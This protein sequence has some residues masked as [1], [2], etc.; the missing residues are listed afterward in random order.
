MEIFESHAKYGL[1]IVSG[2]GIAGEGEGATVGVGGIK[3]GFKT[4]QIGVK[5]VPVYTIPPK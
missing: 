5:T 2:S 3:C 4:V 1:R